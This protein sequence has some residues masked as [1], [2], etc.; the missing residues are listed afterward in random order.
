MEH[1]FGLSMLYRYFDL[2]PGGMLVDYDSIS[3]PW[4]Q[5]SIRGMKRL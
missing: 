4:L 5:A 1:K 3:V 2:S